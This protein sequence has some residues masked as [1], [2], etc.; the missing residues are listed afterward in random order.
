MQTLLLLA[1]VT[2]QEPK[3]FDYPAKYNRDAGKDTYADIANHTQNFQGFGDRP[4]TAHENCHGI[5]GEVNMAQFATTQRGL[6]CLYVGSNKAI[7]FE[8]PK[9]RSALVADFVP[10]S[11]RNSRFKLYLQDSVSQ[12]WKVDH[13]FY[14][15]DE[16]N[17]Y[18]IGA[19]VAVE[20]SEAGKKQNATN[21]ATGQI[22]FAAY[23]VAACLAIEK[24]EP[25]YFRKNPEFLKYVAW[26]MRRAFDIYHRGQ[27]F[28][29]HN[30]MPQFDVYQTLKTSPD[31][32]PIRQ[33]ML[34]TLKLNNL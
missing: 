16:W 28:K 2:G 26:N 33:F 20:D 4:T 19:A 27:K 32:E 18:T 30:S 6:A 21:I 10:K 5:C 34:N 25:D 23:A 9:I 15:I 12:Q 11:L 31:A 7:S 8:H 29:E 24:H 3:F 1:L 17:A 22:E 14:L 13:C